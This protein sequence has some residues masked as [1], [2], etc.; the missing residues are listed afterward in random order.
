M[1]ANI[2]DNGSTIA[3]AGD[4]TAPAVTPSASEGAD[5]SD[6]VNTGTS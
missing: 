5:N 1:A 3:E 4:N 6:F 2:G